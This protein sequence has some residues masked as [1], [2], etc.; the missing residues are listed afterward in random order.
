MG[1][2]KMKIIII[3]AGGH[4]RVV[5]E[6]LRHDKNM[7]V[8]AFVDNQIRGSDERI[9]GI[10]VLGPHSVVLKLIDDGV[11][12]FVVAVGDN[13]IRAEHFNNFIK[14]GLDPV[15]A[16]HPTSTIAYDVKIG[17]G[18]VICMSANIST[19]AQIG[20][21]TIINTNAIIEHEDVIE[22]HVHIGPGSSLA[23]RVKVKKGTFVG[24]GCI[25]KEY[26]TIGEN[27]I[28]G[29][30]SVVLNDIPDNS[31]AVGTPAK[32]IKKNKD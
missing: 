13:K 17:K 7:D 2:I 8:V 6:N 12:G 28:I 16:I 3:G 31:I 20:N 9:M 26:T 15:N 4:A 22:D 24:I 21:N 14:M 1:C 11:K 23:G 29:A 18:V 19:G 5:Y 25:V 30:G 32:K 10:P 27:C